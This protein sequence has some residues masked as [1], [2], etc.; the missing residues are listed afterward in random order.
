M[1]SCVMYALMHYY[2]HIHTCYITYV[3]HT[4]VHSSIKLHVILMV[5]MKKLRHRKSVLLADDPTDSK[6]GFKLVF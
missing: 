3:R 2:I 5:Q 4:Y 6:L 1:P